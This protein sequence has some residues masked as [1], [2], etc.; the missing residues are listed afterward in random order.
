ML[1]DWLVVGSLPFWIITAA[2]VAGIIA[3][4]ENEK[5]L[6][7]T[8]CFVGYLAA[9]Q[10]AGG[11]DLLHW[12]RDHLEWI[13]GGLAGYLVLGAVWGV[14]KWYFFTKKKAVETE[15]N[16]RQSRKDFLRKGIVHP[17]D[18]A[19]CNEY[20]KRT[21]NQIGDFLFGSGPPADSAGK[22]LRRINLPDATEETT[23]PAELRAAW[24]AVVQQGHWYNGSADISIIPPRPN[25]H[26]ST[27]LTWMTFWPASLFWTLLNDPVRA[28]FQH[29]Y[30]SMVRTLQNI[31]NHAFSH[32]A[33][34]HAKDTKADVPP[35]PP[36]SGNADGPMPPGSPAPDSLEKASR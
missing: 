36:A 16:Y 32:V 12:M 29:I 30:A 10:L 31:S 22:H 24:Q 6:W 3:A 18:V 28:A 34:M 25:D 7:A 1:V 9:M 11:V 27:I 19:K 15:E 20:T 33:E 13:A 5:G 14:A 21:C 35:A 26:K 4:V 17:D 8:V 2:I 23:V